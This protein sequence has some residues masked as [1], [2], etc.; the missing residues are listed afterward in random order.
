MR[1]AC[2]DA[3]SGGCAARKRGHVCV[4]VRYVC[5]HGGRC[6]LDSLNFLKFSPQKKEFCRLVVASEEARALLAAA[7][8]MMTLRGVL[9]ARRH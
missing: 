9:P 3:G 2:V 1:G 7:H 4:C 6:A 8:F 5:T